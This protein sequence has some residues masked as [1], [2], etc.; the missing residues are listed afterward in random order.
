MLTQSQP[1]A[2]SSGLSN[3]EGAGCG[4]S[5]SK[6]SLA[7]YAFTL[8]AP[9]MSVKPLYVNNQLASASFCR[10]Y[11]VHLRP[12]EAH[13]N[14]AATSTS[15]ARPVVLM[16]R[17]LAPAMDAAAQ[18]PA[19][20]LLARLSRP[21]R[22]DRCNHPKLSAELHVQRPGTQPVWSFPLGAGDHRPLL[23]AKLKNSRNYAFDKP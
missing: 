22:S 2:E 3:L 19:R 18:H 1:Y 4:N 5:R 8:I 14:Y 17:S 21:R 10:V 11:T 23:P 7:K 15:F 13:A 16:A 9:V 12:F 6:F 20:G